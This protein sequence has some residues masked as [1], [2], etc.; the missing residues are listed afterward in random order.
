[1]KL[2][3]F[4]LNPGDDLRVCIERYVAD[5]EIEA[6]TVISGV[7]GLSKARLRMAGAK[8]FK[9]LEGIFELVSITGTVSVNGSHLHV[10]IADEEGMTIGGHLAKGCIIRTT[11][12]VVILEDETV[13]YTR[14]KD[15]RTG[16]EELRITPVDGT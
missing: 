15:K 6:G 1:M 5:Q 8:T 16:F 9:D 12:E 10:S 13:V 4:K 14:V 11:A 2:H 3:T 7:A